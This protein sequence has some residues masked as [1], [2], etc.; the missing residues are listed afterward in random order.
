MNTKKTVIAASIAAL[1]AAPVAAFAKD[2]WEYH[3]DQWSN[4]TSYGNVPLAQD[5]SEAWGPWSEFIAPAAGGPV[6]NPLQFIGEASGERYRPHPQIPEQK[7]DE[8][9]VVVPPVV[10]AC[11]AGMACG[12]AVFQNN[13]QGYDSD[14]GRYRDAGDGGESVHPATF[15]VR[16]N[17]ENAPASWRLTSLDETAPHF[18]ESGELVESYGSLSHYFDSFRDDYSSEGVGGAYIGGESIGSSDVAVGNQYEL[19]GYDSYPID[20]G[21]GFARALRTYIDGEEG[22]IYKRTHGV[23]IAGIPT[24]TTDMSALRANGI[25][26]TYDG[27]AFQG[28]AVH[29]DVNFGTAQWSGS[30]NGGQDGGGHVGFNASGG[31]TGSNIQSTSVSALD[32]PASGMVKGTFYGSQAAALGGV[33]DVTKAGGRYVDIFLTTKN[34]PE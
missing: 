15:D 33:V 11:A 30:W 10:E 21:E 14:Y 12:Y 20:G 1:L 32:G 24:A 9:P 27:R 6:V 4:V 26:A 16:L 13:S 23:F 3:E 28:A 29:F 31:I 17:D 22:S 25:Q 5:S 7:K 19:N 18:T 2:Q 8:P 34:V